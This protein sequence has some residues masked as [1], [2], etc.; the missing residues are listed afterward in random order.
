MPRMDHRDPTVLLSEREQL[1]VGL[2][3]DELNA[4][5]AHVGLPAR[6]LDDLHAMATTHLRTAQR[7]A[8]A[9]RTS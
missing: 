5:R 9:E 7:A 8:R 1:V 4:L 3:L 6:S 2:L